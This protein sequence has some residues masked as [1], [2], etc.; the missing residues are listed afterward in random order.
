MTASFVL[1][2][3][4]TF[5]W[6]FKDEETPA[7][8]QLLYRMSHESAVVP[9]LWYFEVA[10]GLLVGERKGRI[11]RQGAIEFMALLNGFDIELDEQGAERAFA[12][13][14]GAAHANSLTAYDAVY[15]DLAVRRRLPLAS[16]DDDL[17]D[18]VVAAGLPVLGI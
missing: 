18:A 14:F 1:D 9:T 2:A 5:A 11:T 6:C 3:S 13:V 7:S 4:L 16:R 17:R 12:Y 15:Y 10:N 8:K